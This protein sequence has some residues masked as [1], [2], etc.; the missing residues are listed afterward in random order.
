MPVFGGIGAH[1]FYVD[2]RHTGTVCGG[3]PGTSGERPGIHRIGN[4]RPSEAQVVLGHCVPDAVPF[5]AHLE[6][7]VAKDLL[8]GVDPHMHGA[9]GSTQCAGDCGLADARTPAHDDQHRRRLPPVGHGVYASSFFS[10]R[11]FNVS[12]GLTATPSAHRRSC[13]SVTR[14]FAEG[15]LTWT[16]IS[17]PGAI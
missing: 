12:S 7:R 8:N 17:V 14:C 3:A 6:T 11:F 13:W 10:R 2:R 15:S 5:L 4:H 9:D 1:N 16:S